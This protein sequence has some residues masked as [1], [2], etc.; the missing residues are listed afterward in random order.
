MEENARYAVG[1]DVGTNTV[2]AVMGKIGKDGSVSVVGYGEAPS[3]GIRRGRV[4]ELSVPTSSLNTCLRA[5]E[6]MSG[7]EVKGATV[8]INGSHIASTKVDGMIAV[9]VADHEIDDNDLDRIEETAITGKIPANRE[10]LAVVP[11]EYILDGQGGIREPLGMRGARLEIRA[12]VIS[13]L[14]PDCDN[15]RKIF[16]NSDVQVKVRYLEPSVMAAARAVLTSRQLENGVGVVDMGGSTTSLA[17]YDE[18]ELQFIGVIPIGSN[19]VTND[20]ATVLKTIPEVA[21]EIKTRFA[22][23]R[24]GENDKEIVIKRGRDEYRFAR[25]EV[26]EVVEARLEEIFE[27]VRKMLKAAG[28]DRRLPEGI[29]LVGGGSKLRDID[30]YARSQV[31]LAVRLGKPEGI[32]GVSEEV[33]KP[34]YSTAVGLMMLDGIVRD[35][36][37]RESDKGGKDKAKKQKKANSEGIVARILKIFK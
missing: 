14:A 30:V 5:I 28:Y 26:D 24:F 21:E 10:T 13:A 3:E 11:Y 32:L 12:N 4:K 2:R 35:M 16:E 34:E 18:G 19:D 25:K 23:G 29:V 37:P 22:S 36:Q 17:I 33:M 20:L 1:I 6:S 9:G 31:E 8:N 15:Q 27:G 7:I